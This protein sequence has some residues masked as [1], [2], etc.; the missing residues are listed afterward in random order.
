MRIPTLAGYAIA[1]TASI[2]L[3]AGCSGSASGP[4]GS[5]LPNQASGM[6]TGHSL[7]GPHIANVHNVTPIP[8]K[9]AGMMPRGLRV[10]QGKSWMSGDVSPD[11][12]NAVYLADNIN[13]NV[14][15]YK[16]TPPFG[17][18]GSLTTANGYGW[19]A[20]ASKKGG[21]LLGQAFADNIDKYTPCGTT[22]TAT[23]SGSGAGNAY[24]IAT[25]GAGTIYAN[26]WPNNL[27]DIFVHGNPTFTQTSDP[28]MGLPYKVAVDSHNN[29]WLS[30]WNISF[31][32]QQIDK[33][34]SG[35]TG[36][37]TFATVASPSFPGGLVVLAN[38]KVI[39]DNQDGSIDSY[40]AGGSLLHTFT[41]SNGTNPLDY[42]DLAFNAAKKTRL[43]GANIYLCSSSFGICGS[44]QSQKLA[45]ASGLVGPLNGATAGVNNGEPLGVAAY[46][47][48]AP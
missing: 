12:C 36:C 27:I 40:S 2:A 20:N 6:S 7:S 10:P 16:G 15:V 5:S 24:G 29:V 19:G 44:A 13:L 41:Y 11:K 21:I 23:Y 4:T 45:K 18:I 38:G 39:V 33:C 17:S 8:G 32:E 9:L 42:T 3:L 26:E 1:A 22:P 28:N 43:W 46:P 48:G 30:G 31:T 34:G 14:D 25:D 37:S 35:V 47:A